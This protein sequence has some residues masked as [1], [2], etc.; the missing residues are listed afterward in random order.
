VVNSLGLPECGACPAHT[1][2]MTDKQTMRLVTTSG[3]LPTVV[4][5]QVYLLMSTHCL[6]P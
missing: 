5:V 6:E 2:L 4:V 1:V 3:A